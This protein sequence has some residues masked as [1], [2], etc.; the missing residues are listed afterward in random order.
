MRH[1]TALTLALLTTTIAAMPNSHNLLASINLIHEP[2]WYWYNGTNTKESDV[3]NLIVRDQIGCLPWT[4]SSNNDNQRLQILIADV[5]G[6]LTAPYDGIG[7]KLSGQGNYRLQL[8]T[9]NSEEQETIWHIPLR[10]SNDWETEFY[11]FENFQSN[12]KDPKF[13]SRSIVALS[14]IQ[15]EQDEALDLC[16]SDVYLYTPSNDIYQ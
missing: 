11:P 14:V 3:Q 15:T 6:L 13:N 8:H 1:L 16:L 2:A 10:L 9:L 4:Q 5:P 12:R 7:V